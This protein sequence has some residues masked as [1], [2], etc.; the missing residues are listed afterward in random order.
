MTNLKKNYPMVIMLFRIREAKGRLRIFERA[1][2]LVKS[3]FRALNMI[4]L[5]PKLPSL[6]PFSHKK[7]AVLVS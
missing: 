1:L 5:V 4:T 3:L 6:K 7:R 2:G